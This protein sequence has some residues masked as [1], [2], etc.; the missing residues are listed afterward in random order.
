MKVW[1]LIWLFSSWS[2]EMQIRKIDTFKT[3]QQCVA[4]LDATRKAKFGDF[5]CKEGM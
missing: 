5:Y 2:G 3:E 1:V 4:A